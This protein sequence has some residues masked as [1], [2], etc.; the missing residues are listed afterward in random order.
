[1]PILSQK[2]MRNVQQQQSVEQTNITRTQSIS[3]VKNLIRTAIS[4]IAYVRNLFPQDCFE[5]RSL[6]GVNLQTLRPQSAGRFGP[7]TT[8]HLKVTHCLRHHS[9]IGR[10]SCP[11]IQNQSSLSTGLSMESSMRSTRAISRTWCLP[12]TLPANQAPSSLNAISS[13]WTTPPMTTAAVNR[14]IIFT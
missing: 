7:P 3:L 4:S 1:M 12:S 11:I 9:S 10:L 13:T 2:M 14:D 6:S 5:E 8:H